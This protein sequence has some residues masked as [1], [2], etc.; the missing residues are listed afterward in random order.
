M[1]VLARGVKVRVLRPPPSRILEGV[2]LGA[3]PFEQGRVYELEPAVANVLVLWEYAVLINH[4]R[5]R[6]KKKVSRPS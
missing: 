6:S 5:R 3:R 4:S 1:P 2:D